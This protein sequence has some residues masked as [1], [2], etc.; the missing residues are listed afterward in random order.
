MQEIL[1]Y[2][3]IYS[4][5]ASDFI[6]SLNDAKGKPVCVRMNCNGGDVFGS[7]GMIAKFQSYEGTK[8]I[9]VDGIAASAAAFM[10]LYA[11]DVE[12][13]DVSKFLFHRAAMGG[14]EYEATLTPDELKMLDSVNAGYRASLEAKCSPEMF[15]RVSGV[16]YDEMFSMTDRRDVVLN[17]SQMKE[18]GIV[19]RITPLTVDAKSEILS[20]A[21]KYNIAAFAG[22]VNV[23]AI[24]NNINT[25]KM[26]I[27]DLKAN[28]PELYTQVLAEGARTEGIRVKAW[29][30]YSKIDATTAIAGVVEGKELTQDVEAEFKVKA[31]SAHN[32]QTVVAENAPSVTTPIPAVNADTDKVQWEATRKSIIANVSQMVNR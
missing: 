16:T 23:S 11:N 30:A 26:T 19:K 9:K 5:S 22:E 20:L 31:I 2:G 6:K 8:S 32:L 18:L 10:L 21:S 3:G 7:Y 4:Y 29:L 13:L 28:H 25:K 27:T 15:A 14:V 24:N 12:C 1:L 17:A